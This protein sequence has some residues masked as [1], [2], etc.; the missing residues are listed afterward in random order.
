MIIVAAKN[1]PKTWGYAS[2]GG[3]FVSFWGSNGNLGGTDEKGSEAYFASLWKQKR[4][5]SAG[6]VRIEEAELRERM[7]T[8]PEEFYA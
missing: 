6:F 2:V 4:T 3:K 5:N 7:P 1:G 8:L